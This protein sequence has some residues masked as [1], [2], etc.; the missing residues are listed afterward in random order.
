MLGFVFAMP[1]LTGCGDANTPVIFDP[2]TGQHPAGWYPSGHAIVARANLN[3]CAECHGAQFNGGISGVSCLRCHGADALAN[4]FSC[5][6]CHGQP[7]ATGS[8]SQH[9]FSFVYCFDCHGDPFIRNTHDNGQI[10]I[11]I[12]PLYYSKNLVASY[13]PSACSNVRCHGGPK[14]QDLAQAGATPP[15]YTPTTTDPWGSTLTVDPKCQPCHVYGAADYNSYYS[16]QHYVHVYEEDYN[17]VSCHDR[18]LLAVNHFTY[19]NTATIEGPASATIY[20]MYQYNGVTCGNPGC[21]EGGRRW[22]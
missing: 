9:V 7:P 3:S 14:T 11:S 21:H 8:H 17:C 2:D 16:G 6:T 13:A 18:T 22:R 5:S 20:S 15:R 10:N 1:L 4:G 12:S 19:L